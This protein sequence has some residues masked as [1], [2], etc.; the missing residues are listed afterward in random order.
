MTNMSQGSSRS[1]LAHRAG[2]RAAPR[3]PCPVA[4]SPSPISAGAIAQTRRPSQPPTTQISTDL[5][6]ADRQARRARRSCDAGAA[7]AGRRRSTT[8]SASPMPTR[9]RCRRR[10][11]RVQQ[12]RRQPTSR[13]QRIQQPVSAGPGLCASSRFGQAAVR[14][15][16]AG[17]DG[18]E[19][20]QLVLR[21]R[22]LVLAQPAA[23]LTDGHHR[24]AQHS[25]CRRSRSRRR[26]TGS[27]GS[28]QRCRGRRRA[29]RAHRRRQPAAARRPAG[30]RRTAAS[31]RPRDRPAR[32][33]AGDGG[34][35]APLPDAA[36]RPGRG[37]DPRPVDRRDQGGDDQR[38]VLPG[39]FPRPADHARRAAGRGAGAG[40]RRARGRDASGSPARASWSISWRSTRRSSASPVEPG[41][42]LGSRSNSSRSAPAS[43]SSRARPLID[44]KVACEAKF[45]AMI[46]D[47]PER[48]SS[49]QPLELLRARTAARRARFIAGRSETGRIQRTI[50][51]KA[52][53]HPDYHMIKVQMTDGTV[54]ETRSTWGKE[55]DTMT[56]EIDP[57]VAPGL[58]R[59][60]GRCSMRA[61]GSRASTSASAGCRSPRSKLLPPRTK[62]PGSTMVGPGFLLPQPI[63]HS[64]KGR[65]CGLTQGIVE[66]SRFAAHK[67]YS[68]LRL[69]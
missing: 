36:G 45:T 24:R 51:M 1:R 4:A 69:G 62:G 44:G 17:G 6:A 55:G 25:W 63:T 31:R 22:P 29:R 61:A 52:D 14:Y 37:A 65:L 23:D 47:P 16:G 8:A 27:R 18:G 68:D 10:P 3:R 64:G 26:Q 58:D 41:V 19:A 21:R 67:I 7:A 32:Y 48:L 50:A 11:T 53:T 28:S 2:R 34:A 12:R 9:R 66:P 40:R 49:S 33:R 46:A 57:L 5:Q 30:E 20:R 39:A 13:S 59:R 42:L 35:A 54:Y 56:L 38:G 15:R 60:R 43:A